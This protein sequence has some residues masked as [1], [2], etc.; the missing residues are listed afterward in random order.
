MNRL[1]WVYFLKLSWGFIVCVLGVFVAFCLFVCLFIFVSLGFFL[2][3][4]WFFCLFTF[5]FFSIPVRSLLAFRAFGEQLGVSLL[6]FQKDYWCDL[7]Y[8]YICFWEL[9]ERF[10]AQFLFAKSSWAFPF[11]M[12]SGSRPVQYDLAQLSGEKVCH[13]LPAQIQICLRYCFAA[14]IQVWT[15]YNL[16]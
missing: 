9:Q 1:Q 3:V 6:N 14:E 12:N 8:L 10:K 4:G 7:L 16:N 15:I 13:D 5:F 11:W 2:C